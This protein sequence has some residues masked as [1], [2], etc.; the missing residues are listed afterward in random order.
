MLSRKTTDDA[1]NQYNAFILPNTAGADYVVD[2]TNTVLGCDGC[3]ANTTWFMD[4]IH[5]TE[6]G[7]TQIEVPLFQAA[8]DALKH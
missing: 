2:F 8:V 7:V 3:N 1:K 6:Q 5:P 4:G